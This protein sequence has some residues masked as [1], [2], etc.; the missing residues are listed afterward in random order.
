M[1]APGGC[2]L[3]GGG[4]HRCG[5]WAGHPAPVQR[6]VRVRV[7]GDAWQRMP[8]SGTVR[9]TATAPGGAGP[10]ARQRGLRGALPARP[11]GAGHQAG[12]RRGRLRHQRRAERADVRLGNTGRVD[13]DGRI[14][15]VLPAGVTVLDP[16]VRLHHGRPPPARCELGTLAAGRTAQLRLPVSA[17]PEAQRQA[18]LAGAVLGQLD[19]RSGRARQVQMSFRITAA[20]ALATPVASPPAP[21]GSQGVL[22]AGAAGRQRRR[23]RRLGTADGDPA[24]RGLHAAGGVRPHAGDHLPARGGLTAPAAGP[25]TAPT[26]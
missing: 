5:E 25:S 18:P 12:R 17:T 13:A 24:D 6:P 23:R 19:P 16:P 26:E 11:A 1:P 22:A 21:T 2:A 4:E 15:V 20:A 3:A 8:L 14:E 10:V 7:N 9:V